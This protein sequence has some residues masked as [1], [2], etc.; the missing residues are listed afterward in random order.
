[1]P[2]KDKIVGFKVTAEEAQQIQDMA[3]SG[4]FLS[5]SHYLRSV[6]LTDGASHSAEVIQIL[7]ADNNEIINLRQEIQQLKL[8]NIELKSTQE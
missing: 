1:M 2:F 7:R 6:A 8:E 3:H 4:G 5:K